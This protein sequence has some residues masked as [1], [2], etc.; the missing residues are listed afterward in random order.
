MKRDTIPGTNIG[1]SLVDLLYESRRTF[2]F[3]LYWYRI[4][5]FNRR[6]FKLS[7]VIRNG[8]VMND[9]KIEIMNQNGSFDFVA[10]AYETGAPF[11][12][13]YYNIEESGAD[14]KVINM[15]A[16]CFESM[17]KYITTVYA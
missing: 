7:V 13:N 10:N 5:K 16:K 6:T 14:I 4:V 8:S 12:N 2:N 1:E 9:C 15:C 3:A 11:K 17:V